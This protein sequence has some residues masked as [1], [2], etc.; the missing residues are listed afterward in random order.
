MWRSLWRSPTPRR[1]RPA[2]TRRRTSKLL[3]SGVPR[4]R[5]QGESR[6]DEA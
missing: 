6:G 2:W 4:G 3:L 1:P 5:C